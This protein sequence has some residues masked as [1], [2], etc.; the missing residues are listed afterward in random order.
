MTRGTT[1]SAPKEN[2]DRPVRA[3][4]STHWHMLDMFANPLTAAHMHGS[5]TI[6]WQKKDSRTRCKTVRGW[7]HPQHRTLPAS[8]PPFQ[9]NIVRSV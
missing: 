2:R 1:R 8:P 5:S 9:V 4:A 7:T 6:V 3:Y